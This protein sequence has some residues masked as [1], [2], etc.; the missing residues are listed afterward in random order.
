MSLLTNVTPT[1][2]IKLSMSKFPMDVILYGKRDFAA[3]TKFRTPGWGVILGYGEG[4]GKCN[5]KGVHERDTDSK[6]QSRREGSGIEGHT[7]ETEGG[8]EATNPRWPWRQKGASE[9][10]PPEAGKGKK[11]HRP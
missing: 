3:T 1:N 6:R 10:K 7:W 4:G 2:S 11:I 9:Q 5:R 8:P